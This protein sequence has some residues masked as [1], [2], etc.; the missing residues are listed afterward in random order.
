M[1]YS[2]SSRAWRL[3]LRRP[4]G[5]AGRGD[6]SRADAAVARQGLRAAG[7]APA[8]NVPRKAHMRSV[9]PALRP[10]QR[11]RRAA[12]AMVGGQ[13]GPARSARP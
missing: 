10:G 13:A 3:S 11:L 9:G 2:C 1:A 6:G 4:A 8:R 5:A 7:G 12:L